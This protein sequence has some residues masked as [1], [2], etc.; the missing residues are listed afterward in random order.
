MKHIL[1]SVLAL[2]SVVCAPRPALAKWIGLSSEHFQFV[3]DASE[4][5]M[6]RIAQ[7]LEQFREV[8]GQVI[9]AQSTR[10]PVPT[11]VVVFQNDRSLAPFRPVFQGKAV[12]V[13]GYFLAGEDANYIALN[14]QQNSD[15][16]GVIFHEY[17]HYLMASAVGPV[18]IW[19]GEGLAELYQTFEV[20][21]GGRTALIGRPDAD[22]LALL[23]GLPLMPVTQLIG[24]QHDSPM[25]NEGN[26]RGLLYAQS[27]ALVHYLTFAPDRAGQ[28]V[29]YVNA[30]RAGQPAEQAFGATFGDATTL[31]RQLREYVRAY[32]FR[33]LRVEFDDKI[34]AA[35][36]GAAQAVDDGESSGYL[37]ELL[38]R[39]NRGS[40]ARTYLT[41]AL[42]KTPD[43]ARAWAALGALELRSGNEDASLQ[44]L[45]KAAALAP[46]DAGIQ[47]A[48]GRA[49]TRRADR[50]TGNGDVLYAQ[51]RTALAR[52]LELDPGN[53]STLITL[54]E[55]EMASG[56]NP[57]AALD[58]VKKAVAAAPAREEYRLMLGQA[59][60]MNA[61]FR[62]ATGTLSLLMARGS[63]PE[64]RDAARLALAR[65]ANAE[66]ATRQLLEAERARAGGNAVGPATGVTAP[67]S[68]AS[69][70]GRTSARLP[71]LPQGQ[72]MPD[73]RR[74]QPG[75]QRVLG[76]FSSVECRAE[77]VVLQIDMPA[78]AVRL[79][80]RAFADVEFVSYR[81]DSPTGIPCGVQQPAYRVLATYRPDTPVAGADSPHRAVAIELLPDGYT[82]R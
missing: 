40:D 72:F 30:L 46:R 20:T 25:Y 55:V 3:G 43:A 75:E 41:G 29:K 45:E 18:P 81:P 23:Q 26:R 28:L 37:G 17:A 5:D 63:R 7:Q 13:G 42:Q 2:V 34:A 21:N 48:Y 54:A 70:A 71:D 15:A 80:A 79:G 31:D 1:A 61:D 27:W 69:P 39:L 12:E 19:L 4:R 58:L 47:S 52:A 8:V 51:A 49:L 78:G 9:S 68:P 82:P 66:V 74:V 24:V 67:T 77:A 50:G 59:L 35:P 56:S 57:G 64:I 36:I 73:L 53:P 38:A 22:N 32:Q 10:S 76:V 14:A 44:M 62:G 60:A 6:R 16:Y 33:A 11:F 65:V